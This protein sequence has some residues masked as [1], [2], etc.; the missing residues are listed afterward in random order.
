MRRVLRPE[1]TIILIETLGSGF[2]TPH[3]PDHLV[4][5]YQFLANQGFLS[6]W[7]RTDYRFPSEEEARCMVGFFFGLEQAEKVHGPTITECTG[8]WWRQDPTALPLSPA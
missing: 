1:G 2:E 5:Y 4:E 6:T 3:P 7:L 8:L